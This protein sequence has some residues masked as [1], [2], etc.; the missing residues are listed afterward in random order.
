MR[1]DFYRTP[2]AALALLLAG[3]RPAAADQCFP[4]RTNISTA[5]S[6]SD[7]TSPVGVCTTGTLFSPTIGATTRFTALTVLPGLSP[8]VLVYSGELVLT[9]SDGTITIHDHGLLNS[10]TAYYFE[11]QQVVGGTG[12]YARASGL[13]TSRGLST[14][15]GFQGVLSGTIC[16]P[17]P[18]I[19]HRAAPPRNYNVP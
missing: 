4:V 6:V 18:Q 10:T 16:N 19:A 11:V 8:D 5:Y 9:F 17:V 13:L 12:A 15:T 7:C 3:S 2:A 1:L 14:P